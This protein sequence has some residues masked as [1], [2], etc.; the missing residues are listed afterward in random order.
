[1]STTSA[2]FGLQ[3]SF[4]PSGEVRPAYGSISVD[5]T[6]NIYQQSPVALVDGLLNLSAAGSTNRAIGVFL[7]VRYVDVNGRPVFS[8]KWVSQ[9]GATEIVAWYT[10]DQLIEYQVQ[11]NA[12]LTVEAVGEQYPWTVNNT[13][14]GN[15]TTGLSNVMLD[16]SG[17]VTPPTTSQMRITGLTDGPTN[18]WGDAFPVVT[19]QLSQHQNTADIAG[20]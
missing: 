9:A 7:G 1:M 19:V 18:A 13:T 12:T 10:S 6:T 4:H 20:Y 15:L 14:S 17:V 2:P 16:V 3:P 8:N 5:Y 11:A